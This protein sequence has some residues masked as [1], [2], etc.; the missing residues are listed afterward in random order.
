MM[1]DN[2]NPQKSPIY[3]SVTGLPLRFHFEWPFQKS[4]AGADFWYLHADIRL[5]T[6]ADLHALVAVNSQPRCGKCCL[7]LSLET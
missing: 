4:T 6:S 2:G 5:A 1:G 3:V 7:H